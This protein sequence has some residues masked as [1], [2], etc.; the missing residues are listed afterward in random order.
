[1]AQ[2]D[3]LNMF[4]DVFF[5]P[6]L[7]N[8]L[9][10]LIFQL[11]GHDVTGV[12]NV[13]GGERLSKYEFA[14]KLAETFGYATD[15]VQAVSVERFPFTAPRPRDM[16]LD[17]TRMHDVLGVQGPALAPGLDR[18]AALKDEGWPDLVNAAATST[19][20]SERSA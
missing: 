15:C 11:A 17:T 10:D 20:A 12:L 5:T 4:R 8:D 1:L 13:A 2:A 18:L 9:S 6:I 14:I 16:S 3:T 7:V 19:I